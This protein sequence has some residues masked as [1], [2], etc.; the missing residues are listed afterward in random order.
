MVIDA[1]RLGGEHVLGTAALE[2]QFRPEWD[3]PMLGGDEAVESYAPD[4]VLLANG[5]GGTSQ[6]HRR[7]DLFERFKGLGY[8]FA[9]VRHPSAIVARDAKL[10]EG[11]QLMAG[12]I[13]QT[14][15][16]LGRNVIVNTAASVDHDCS[17]ADHA[18]IAPGATLSGAVEVGRCTHVGA[19]AVVIQGRR[20]GDDVLIGAG[21][22]VV[23]DI[24][25][26]LRVA[27]VP[28]RELRR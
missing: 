4:T 19:G 5:I 23:T 16:R 18:H 10:D 24:P 27:G 1:L 11:V 22:V 25:A 6:P 9:M 14:G 26:G 2:R 7:R 20:I 15:A 12:A 28:A 8:R 17:I 13:V 21:A 3:V